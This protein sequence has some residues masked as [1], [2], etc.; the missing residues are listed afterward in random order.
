MKPSLPTTLAALRAS[1]WQ[2]RPVKEEL[3]QNLLDLLR[4]GENAFP[5]IVGYDTTVIPALQNAILARHDFILLGLRG[6][7]KTRILRSLVNLLDDAIPAVA[8][9]P[10]RDNPL[11]PACTACRRRLAEQ[12]DALEIAWIPRA[13]RYREKLATPDVSIADL[14]GDIDPIKAATLRLTYA[15]EDV[16][17][18]GIL[19]RTNRGIFAINV[20]PDLQPRIQVGLLNILEE[21]DVQVRGFPLRLPLDLLLVFSA[22]PEDYTNRGNIITPLKDRIASQILTHYPLEVKDAMAITAQEAWVERA[23]GVRFLIPEV[24]REMVEAISFAARKSEFI[25]QGSGVSARLSISA[26]ECLVSN[27]ERRAAVTGEKTVWPR[28]CDLFAAVPAVTGKIE[29]VHEG[30][31]QGAVAIAKR[32]IGGAVGGAFAARFPHAYQPSGR[33]GGAGAKAGAR[34]P[35]A[36][37]PDDSPYQPIVGW[38]AKGNTVD[39]SDTQPQAEYRAQLDRVE[40]LRALVDRHWKPASGEDAALGME[41]LLEGLHQNSLIAKEDLDQRVSYKDML[42]EMFQGMQSAEND[43]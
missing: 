14:I 25:D 22:N 42:K 34:V 20:L 4:R 32:L 5:G 13:D 11:A 18:W 23:G 28:V 3:R 12:G 27:L 26:L 8:G 1:G 19:P 21:R 30:E 24:F 33:R 35:K 31:Q 6:Q 10:I 29:L 2:A 36:E 15:D 43:D 17:H 38:F 37:T 7:A 16:I 40:G 9:C 39:L 41:L